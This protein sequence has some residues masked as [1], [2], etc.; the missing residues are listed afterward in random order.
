MPSPQEWKLNNYK[1][2]FHKRQNTFNPISH[3]STQDL[4]GGL[5]KCFHAIKNYLKVRHVQEDVVTSIIMFEW[6]T[7][8][9]HF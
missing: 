4:E 7:L 9:S 3:L 6:F 2:Q 8:K 1:N 5:K